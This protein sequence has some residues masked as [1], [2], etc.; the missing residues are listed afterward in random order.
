MA[1]QRG[2][3]PRPDFLLANRA[4]PKS[5]TPTPTVTVGGDG[6]V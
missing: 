1:V 5:P 6:G 4:L 3:K 2:V